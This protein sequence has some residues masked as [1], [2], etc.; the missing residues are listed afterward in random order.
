MSS[1][2]KVNLQK[3]LSDY[4]SEEI[5]K[6]QELRALSDDERKAIEAIG[7]K[8]AIAIDDL[9]KQIDAARELRALQASAD[10][11]AGDANEQRI[12]ELKEILGLKGDQIVTTQ[13]LIDLEDDNN[14]KIREKNKL[15]REYDGVLQSVAGSIGL[16]NSGLLKSVNNFRKMAVE[17][18]NNEEKMKAFQDSIGEVFSLSSIGASVVES[19]FGAAMQIDQLR[20]SLAATT[21]TGAELEGVLTRAS[22][23]G[24]ESEVSFK[25]SAEALTALQ[26]GLIGINDQSGPLLDNLVTQVAEF[27]KLGISAETTVGIMNDLQATM[28]VTE[29]QSIDLTKSLVM[30]A[31]KFG[32]G[33]KKMAEDFR[34]A[35]SS[36]AA[37]GDE[38][39]EVFEG[40]ALAARNAGTSVD[41]LISIAN[42]FDTFSS[43]ADAAGQLNS[44]LGSTI[45]ATE[46]LM[47]T[48][49]ERIESLVKTVQSQGVA[50]KD[51]DRFTQKA[52]AQAAGI[53]DLSE[54][55]RI[56]GMSMS[57]FKKQQAE[58]KKSQ[59]VQK[60]F[61]EALRMSLPIQEK[62]ALALQNLTANAD[63]IEGVMDAAFVAVESF[64]SVV[65]FLNDMGLMPAIAGFGA[66]KVAAAFLPGLGTLG[67]LA[68]TKLATSLGFVSASAGGAGPTVSVA[69][70]MIGTA[71]SFS[72][73]QILAL[74]A[75]FTLMGLGIG[76]AAYGLSFIVAEFAKMDPAQILAASFG[77][78]AIGLAMV[79]MAYGIGIL[80]IAL[81]TLGN[82]LTL[83][84]VGVLAGLAGLAV[85]L[86]L[87]FDNVAEN[88]TNI[89][90]ALPAISSAKAAMEDINGY[91]ETLETKLAQAPQLQVT[92]KNLALITSQQAAGLNQA[93]AASQTTT[94]QN[95]QEFTIL[96]K[97]DGKELKTEILGT[98][99]N[100]G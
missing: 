41:S 64:A 17:V 74:G 94:V 11:D 40:L 72:A 77:I 67:S 69:V 56:F 86:A 35:S 62:F 59:D 26:T 6:R 46:M 90:K 14:K 12:A 5:A 61:D 7:D 3:Q 76:L 88:I 10:S 34:K 23:A 73:L 20:A 60:K 44:I 78:V 37:H 93:Q 83:V 51:M 25:Q 15:A 100:P 95:S 32:I 42:K 58:V 48:E 18:A 70:T 75:A 47:M 71:A 31:T 49:D 27:D 96:L 84:G 13:Q 4:L 66:L 16:G 33:P 2:E 98:V 54:A 1:Q 91:I 85:G 55:N 9:N 39:I 21:G 52:I 79:P 68:M 97:I 8:R 82:P 36:L 43:A 50:F 53:S 65:Q 80:A 45:S 63:M 87:G 38:S 89:S 99:A 28:G 81:A 29:Q 92:L 24:L 19:T 57:E 22:K 30:S